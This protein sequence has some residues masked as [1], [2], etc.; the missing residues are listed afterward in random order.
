[1]LRKMATSLVGNKRQALK[2]NNDKHSKQLT[3]THTYTHRQTLSN[4][5]THNYT[6]HDTVVYL[7]IYAEGK[8]QQHVQNARKIS[9]FGAFANFLGS[10]L[11]L[12]PAAAGI[13]PAPVGMS[14]CWRAGNT[15]WIPAKA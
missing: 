12:H 1:M 13:Y 14:S 5:H 11:A 4:T 10:F 6:R 2:V 15:S 8:W 9:P 7:F 3:H